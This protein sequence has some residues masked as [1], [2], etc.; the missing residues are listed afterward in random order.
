MKT[1]CFPTI[2]TC[3]FHGPRMCAQEI[4]KT[5]GKANVGNLVK[6]RSGGYYARLHVGGK[7][8]RTSL[9]TKVPEVATP[10]ERMMS[11]VH[12][13]FPKR[14]RGCCCGAVHSSST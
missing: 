8:R 2:E 5:W 1:G 11:D 9:R 12:A 6:H 4:V 7:E 10:I 14:R 13:K 3:Q